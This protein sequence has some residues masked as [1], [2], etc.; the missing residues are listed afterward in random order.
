[1]AVMRTEEEIK[2]VF[3]SVNWVS[4]FQ[5]LKGEED[6]RQDKGPN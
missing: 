2:S 6:Q 1:M 3:P 5:K 4:L